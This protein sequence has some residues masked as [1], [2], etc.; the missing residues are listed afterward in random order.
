MKKKTG[1]LNFIKVKNEHY[2]ESTVTEW[3]EIYTN[4]IAHKGSNIQNIIRTLT[5]K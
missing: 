1:K 3:K 5:T 4:N 2:Q